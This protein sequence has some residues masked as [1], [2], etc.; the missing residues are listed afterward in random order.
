[1]NRLELLIIEVCIIVRLNIIIANDWEL[2]KMPMT[3]CGQKKEKMLGLIK[4][5]SCDIPPAYRRTF[6]GNS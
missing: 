1:M 2:L 4:R 6:P 3:S 5:N